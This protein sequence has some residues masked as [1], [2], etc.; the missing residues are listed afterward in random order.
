MAGKMKALEAI[1]MVHSG[2]PVFN[3]EIDESAIDQLRLLAR[4]GEVVQCEIANTY[5]FFAW[6]QKPSES[7]ADKACQIVKAVR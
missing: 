6:V 1:A 2:K 5:W 3:Y 4:S 7:L